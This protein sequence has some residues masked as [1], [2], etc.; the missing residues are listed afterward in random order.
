MRR[1]WTTVAGGRVALETVGPA[2]GGLESHRSSI[3]PAGPRLRHAAT[4]SCDVMALESEDQGESAMYEKREFT[5]RDMMK[6]S[7]AGG[8]AAFYGARAYG[9]PSP[10]ISPADIETASNTGCPV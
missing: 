9:Q 3:F 10:D 7:G 8:A 5:R 2:R 4:K 1:H 6:Y